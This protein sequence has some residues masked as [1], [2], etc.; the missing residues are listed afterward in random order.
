MQPERQW[1]LPDQNGT[2]MLGHA[3]VVSCLSRLD[4]LFSVTRLGDPEVFELLPNAFEGY[5]A[6]RVVYEAERNLARVLFFQDL[7]ARAVDFLRPLEDGR[8][9]S[10]KKVHNHHLGEC[11]GHG[12]VELGRVGAKLVH[13]CPLRP[14]HMEHRH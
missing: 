13:I 8:G 4:K 10:E 11:G 6:N 1:Q 9:I 5:A 3:R 2:R 14:K 7:A 12:D